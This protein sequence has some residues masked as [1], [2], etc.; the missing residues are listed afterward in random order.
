[1]KLIKILSDRIQIRTDGKEF[2]GTRINDLIL[3]TDGEV[4]LIT[5]VT[6][7]TD[8]DISVNFGEEDHITLS[9]S[10]KV[11][12]CSIIGSLD[13]DGKFRKAIDRYPT[14]NITSREVTAEEFGK[15]LAGYEKNGFRIG[16]YKT[17]DC[18]AYVDGN[19]FFQRHACIVGNTGS[20]KSETV[21]KILEETSRL[22]G[23]NVIVF[24]IHGEYTGLSYAR[25]I[26]IG[27]D[28]GFPI[29]MFGFSDMV[30]NILKIKEE[31]SSVVMSALRKCYYKCCVNANENKP[32]YFDFDELL[33]H[34]KH[35]NN[36]YEAT[37]EF[38]KSGA[39][40]GQMKTVKGEYNGKLSSVIST[41]QTKRMD[42]RYDFL[43]GKSDPDELKYIIK[44]IMDN[45]RPVKNIDLSDIPHDVAISIIGIITKMI[46]EV[47]KMYDPEELC[48]VVLVCDEAHVYIPNNFALSASEKRMVGIFE[49]IAKEGRKFGF[50]L[51]VAS[52]RP[53]ELNKTIMA[54]CANFIVSKL[55]NENDKSMIKG[56]MPDGSE[57]MI[58]ST[59]TFSPGEVLIVGD[60][61]PIPLRI[62]VSLA[63]ERPKSR[64]IDFWQRW[65]MGYKGDLEKA[66][67]DYKKF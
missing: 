46:Y 37:G 25:N 5:T 42:S 30:A 55:N 1:M 64:T 3:V 4:N 47:H 19:K 43:F 2:S 62:Q 38:Y 6:S 59:T 23:S 61:V 53:S 67:S 16:K 31:T 48:P 63:N 65:K 57:S 45:D 15:M 56:M 36:S 20:G 7:I 40:E 52:Q 66:I 60:S 28:I 44:D 9:D 8:N 34:M 35:L 27:T 51:F 41:M 24:D 11:I 39:K 21:A 14:T 50:S 26:K 32:V 10:M 18:P 33:S 49:D 29:W 12:E 17:Y 58:D 13:K 54:Q 22:P